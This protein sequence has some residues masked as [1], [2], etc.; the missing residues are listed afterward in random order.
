MASLKSCLAAASFRSLPKP[1]CPSFFSMPLP[2]L[3]GLQRRHPAR[4]CLG[5]LRL[6]FMSQSVL[7]SYNVHGEPRAPL[8]RASGSTVWLG[9]LVIRVSAVAFV[10]QRSLTVEYRPVCAN[11]MPKRNAATKAP[12]NLNQ[13]SIGA[14]VNNQDSEILC[15]HS[16]SCCW[17]RGSS[18][19]L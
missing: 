3:F 7:M 18:G 15:G 4:R 2:S 17:F 1:R 13:R 9:S 6:W 11:T 5:R 19:A 16:S 8:L 14:C 10:L 12:T